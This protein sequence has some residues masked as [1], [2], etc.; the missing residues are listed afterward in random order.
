MKS[1]KNNNICV[2]GVGR[3]GSAVITQLSKMNCSVLVIEQ[4]EKEAK[5]V[6]DL[7]ERVIV[8]DAAD[9][10]VLKSLDINK[11]NTVVVATPDNIEIVAALLELKVENI[12]ARTTSKRHARVLEQ[13]GVDVIIRPEHEAGVRTALFAANPSF[14]KFSKNLQEIANGFVT[15]TTILKDDSFNGKKIKELNWTTKGVSIVLINRNSSSFVPQGDFILQKDDAVTL[16]GKVE[17]VT[18]LLS[19]INPLN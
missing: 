8:A 10:N 3:F 12:I 6:V 7:A 2:I 1:K 4:D 11:I 5:S 18:E 19:Q 15:T 9:I 16:V 13:I 17:D 14:S